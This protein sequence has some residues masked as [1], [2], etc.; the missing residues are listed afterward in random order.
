M[1]SPKK[2]ALPMVLGTGPLADAMRAQIEADLDRYRPTTWSMK[3]VGTCPCCSKSV[4][5]ATTR[6]TS[7]K[8]GYSTMD[9]VIHPTFRFKDKEPDP[10][11]GLV[12]CCCKPGEWGPKHSKLPKAKRNQK[13]KSS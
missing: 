12:G 11:G 4:Y 3:P 6:Y 10:D 9:N 5:K 13:P 2:P 7:W 8:P 1:T